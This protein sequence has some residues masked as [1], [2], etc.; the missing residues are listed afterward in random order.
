MSESV[1]V[2]G[3]FRDPNGFVFQRAGQLYRQVNSRYRENYDLLMHS[4][5][6]DAL[7]QTGLLVPHT[8]VGVQSAMTQDAYQ[9]IQPTPIPFISYPYEWCFSQL[10][11]AALLILEVQK[12]ALEFGMSLKDSSAYNVQFAN[13]KPIL[14][15]TL[16]L[17]KYCEGRPWIAYRQFCQ[18]FLAPLALISHSDAR[19][20][21][22]CRV[23][24]DG[25]PLDLA[26]TLLPLSTRANFGLLSHVHLHAQAQRH[27]ASNSASSKQDKLS[28]SAFLGLVENLESTIENLRWAPG[29]TGWSDY[30][31][32]SSYSPVA[33]EDKKRIVSSMLNEIAPAPR[34]VWDLGGNIGLFSRIASERGMLTI[35]LDLDPA[36]V[37]QN[38]RQVV[39]QRETTL[40][41][42]V[43]DATNPSPGLGW[44]NRERISLQERGP[45][46]LVL[47]LAFV[48]HLAISNNLPFQKIASFLSQIGR[49]LIIEF[50]PKDDPLVQRLL[51]N[52]EDI[53]EQYNQ[54]GFEHEL[55]RFFRILDRKKIANT[56]RTLYLMAR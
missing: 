44:E 50:V 14:I 8:E 26:S 48:H 9:V 24:L 27:L 51:A 36:A 21:Q 4:G 18:H 55:S 47:A 53:F 5:L 32:V 20:L 25:I 54:D 43:L 7:A 37:E 38:Y 10:K 29:S 11:H 52:R 13:G 33:L 23:Y 16:S 39:K 6:Y 45:A 30:Y 15:D 3:S 31:A 28:R 42:L 46:D 19:L 12:Q 35:S 22:L 40:L 34:M 56:N 2:P 41:P 17:E 1:I 49:S